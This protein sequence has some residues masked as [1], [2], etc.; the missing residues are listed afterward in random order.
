MNRTIP[1]MTAFS[2][3]LLGTAPAT[4][5]LATRTLTAFSLPQG[6]GDHGQV[7]V[8]QPGPGTWTADVSTPYG[9]SAR[10]E[11][12]EPPVDDHADAHRHHPGLRP[13]TDLQHRRPVGAG[14]RGR[15]H[16]GDRPA[17]ADDHALRRDNPCRH[18][19]LGGPWRLVPGRLER[20]EQRWPEPVRG[21]ASRHSL[22]LPG[23][24]TG[25]GCAPHSAGWLSGQLDE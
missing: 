25:G 19:G 10:S 17:R 22:H 5:S 6:T 15:L 16:A 13:R 24:L 3:V 23:R 9:R 18:E 14:C 11:R 12:A 20:R 1:V 2:L 4:V 8:R 21:P 7:E